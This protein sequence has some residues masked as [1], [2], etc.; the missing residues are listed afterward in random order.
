MGHRFFANQLFVH[1]GL[2]RQRLHIFVLA[3]FD[4]FLS[5]FI[6]GTRGR[7]LS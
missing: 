4:K 3:D 1:I 6:A 2:K 5:A 7:D